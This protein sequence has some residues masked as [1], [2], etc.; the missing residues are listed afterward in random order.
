MARCKQFLVGGRR[1]SL[2][3]CGDTSTDSMDNHLNKCLDSTTSKYHPSV[4]ES[5]FHPNMP[6]DQ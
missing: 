3:A 4:S 5:I 2:M 1:W 6:G